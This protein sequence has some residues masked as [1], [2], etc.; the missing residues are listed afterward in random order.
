M[1]HRLDQ[2]VQGHTGGGEDFGV[3]VCAAIAQLALAGLRGLYGTQK[4][5]VVSF[6]VPGDE[7]RPEACLG[8]L[9]YP[10]PACYYTIVR[11][12]LWGFL[13]L[14]AVGGRSSVRKQ[15]WRVVRVYAAGRRRL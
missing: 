9:Q 1:A 15:H 6:V 11:P 7:L 13:V 14:L 3:V 10:V 4:T 2:S 12:L 5:V 8:G